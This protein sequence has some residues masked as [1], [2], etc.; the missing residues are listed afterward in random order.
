MNR[1]ERAQLTLADGRTLSYGTCGDPDGAPLLLLDGPGSRV[2]ASFAAEPAAEAGVQVVA[3]DRPGMGASDPKPG[4]SI[5]DWVDDARELVDALG[6]ERFAVLG[7][8]GGGPYAAAT[9]WGLPT[10]VT[11]LGLLAAMAPPDL[12]DTKV[13]MGS[14]TKQLLFFARRAPFVLRRAMRGIAARAQRDPEAVAA[15][16]FKSRPEDAHVLSR[17]AHRE[18]IVDGMAV[19]WRSVDANVHEFTLMAKPWG[20]SLEEVKTP[21]WLWYGG[22]DTVHP[23][24]MGRAMEKVLPATRASYVPDVGSFAFITDLGPILR[25][26]TGKDGSLPPEPGASKTAGDADQ[27]GVAGPSDQAGDAG[28]SDQAGPAGE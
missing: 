18:I 8:S 11:R 9:A 12:P 28:P 10:R 6:W 27:P 23:A 17:A 3:P 21:T 13:G 1:L 7:V 4:R 26:L 14:A 22:D 25:T 2:V 19:M 20:F 16:T 15:E 5:P 24:A